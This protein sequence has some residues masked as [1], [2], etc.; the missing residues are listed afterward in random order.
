[1][2]HPEV[3]ALPSTRNGKV[4]GR[5]GG[6]RE[7]ITSHASN[8][9]EIYP[10]P[11]GQLTREIRPTAS[12]SLP[13]HK[14]S[15]TASPPIPYHP[16]AIQRL[17]PSI[18]KH[19]TGGIFLMDTSSRHTP[20]D[21][22]SKA[23]FEVVDRHDRRGQPLATVVCRHCGLVSHERVPTEEELNEYYA[24]HYRQDY[25]GE[26]TPSAHRVLRAWEGGQ[27]LLHLLRPYVRPNSHVCEIGA[28]IGCTVKS[29]EM[30]GFHA[31]GIEPGVGFHRYSREVLQTELQP[32]QLEDLPAVPT[33]DFL[34]LVHVIEHF[35]SPRQALERLWKLLR[36][37]G[38]LYVECPNLGA[39]HA[40]PG[41]I[42]HFAHI[43]NFTPDT[44]EMLAESCGFEVL[45]NLGNPNRRVLRYLLTKSDPRPAKIRLGSYQRTR[46]ALSRYSPLTYHLRWG[47]W[48]ERIKRDLDFLSQRIL[49]S[50]RLRRLER[51][52]RRDVTSNAG[53]RAA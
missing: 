6:P 50:A 33:Y 3:T 16:S 8:L 25:H 11:P 27:R 43:H 52:C 39:P 21:L 40:S 31:T 20:C 51:Q 47:Y 24:T 10:D 36:P 35:A 26:I 13:R 18:L 48:C 53:A 9:T 1:M 38:R 17:L 14:L 34:L 5:H 42:F 28:G 2:G 7:R 4:L 32:L 44:L 41:K 12:T 46:E 15:L 45:V 19:L 37:G 23:S 30:A 29:F 49:A 22:C